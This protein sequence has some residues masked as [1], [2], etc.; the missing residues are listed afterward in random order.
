MQACHTASGITRGGESN[1]SAGIQ[2]LT[3]IASCVG[4]HTTLRARHVGQRRNFPLALSGGDD[5]SHGL[6]RGLRVLT[7]RGLT[8][9]HH[10]IC[11]IEHSV[12]HVGGLRTSRA[13]VRNHGVE[14]LGGDDDRLGVLAGNLN[15]ALLNQRNIFQRHLNTKVTTGDHHGIEGQDDGLERLDCLWLLQL[16]DNRDTTA[17]LIHDRMDQFDVG[18]RTDEGQRDE[19]DSQLQSEAQ[20]GD[21]L[22]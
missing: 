7:N 2:A 15:S 22:L 1:H 9:E 21:I 20:V 11:A 5:A 3:D 10:G 12:G 18:R 4:N 19:V 8:R 14:H 13:R 6:N 17:N 16:G